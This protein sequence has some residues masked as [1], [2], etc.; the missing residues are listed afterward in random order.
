MKKY[1]YGY[2]YIRCIVFILNFNKVQKN[3][4]IREREGVPS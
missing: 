4:Y 3:F 1:V 2:S